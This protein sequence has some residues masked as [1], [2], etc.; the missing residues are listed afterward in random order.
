MRDSRAY[1]DTEKTILK[2]KGKTTG[3][4][5]KHNTKIIIIIPIT[6]CGHNTRLISLGWPLCV[7]CCINQKK[8]KLEVKS[9]MNKMWSSERQ[10]ESSGQKQDFFGNIHIYSFSFFFS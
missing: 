3:T 6:P 5:T 2:T 9:G 8:E 10:E 7:L 4:T 1:R